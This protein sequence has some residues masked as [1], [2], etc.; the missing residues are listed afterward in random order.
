[1]LASTLALPGCATFQK[2]NATTPIETLAAANEVVRSLVVELRTASRYNRLSV[3]KVEELQG[4]LEYAYALIVL[5]EDAAAAG[6]SAGTDKY[7]DIIS[8]LLLSVEQELN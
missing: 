8:T 6:D 1:M 4:K 7:L 5:A 2:P 3:A